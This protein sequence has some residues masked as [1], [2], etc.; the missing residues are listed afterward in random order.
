MR[1][2][3]L[4]P[5][6]LETFLGLSNRRFHSPLLARRPAKVAAERWA[7]LAVDIT[8]VDRNNLMAE[9]FVAVC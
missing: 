3:Y 4:F 2:A 6:M 8:S 1:D 9:W 7:R 5:P